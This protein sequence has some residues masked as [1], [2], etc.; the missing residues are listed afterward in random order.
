MLSAC[1][2]FVKRVYCCLTFNNLNPV[3]DLSDELG[4]L[5]QPF[6]TVASPHSTPQKSDPPEETLIEDG[7][8]SIPLRY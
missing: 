2:N 6:E 1:T 8:I 7:K 5:E 3:I 4:A